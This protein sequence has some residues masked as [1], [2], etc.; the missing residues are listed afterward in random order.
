MATRDTGNVKHL[1]GAI[2]DARKKLDDRMSACE[3]A[4][5]E[6][7]TSLTNKEVLESVLDKDHP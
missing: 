7:M 5:K 2:R 6:P 1:V 4:Q 3:K